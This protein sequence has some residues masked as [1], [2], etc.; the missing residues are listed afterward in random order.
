MRLYFHLSR[1]YCSFFVPADKP[2]IS[3][4]NPTVQHG[5]KCRGTIWR[6]LSLADSVD[7]STSLPQ[8]V[9]TE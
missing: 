8:P 5:S 9:K 1:L 6:H 7:I 4:D 2:N 3:E